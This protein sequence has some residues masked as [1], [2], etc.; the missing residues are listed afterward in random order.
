MIEELQPRTLPL[1]RGE[2]KD[3]EKFLQSLHDEMLRQTD[4][5]RITV[6]ML[7][8]GITGLKEDLA[9]V[10]FEQETLEEQL[11]RQ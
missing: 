1:L 2:I 3:A 10:R 9:N 5:G 11:A 6:E 7:N 8:E 4:N